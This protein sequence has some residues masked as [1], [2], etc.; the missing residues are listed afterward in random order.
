VKETLVVVNPASG[1]GRTKKRWPEF[2]R[3]LAGAGL[4]FQV[5]FTT[6]PG[7][8]TRIAR[9]GV[10]EGRALIVAAGGDGTISETA[11]GFFAEGAPI[12]GETRFGVLPTG[13]G[14]DFRRTFE[15]PI[16]PPAAAA[17]L[18][19]GHRR[20]IDAGLVRFVDRDGH[21]E[22][23]VF[24]NIADAG[25]GGD[26]VHR[27]NTGPKSLPGPVTFYLA[28][29][30]S[31]LAWRNRPVAVTIDGLRRELVSQQVV[32]ANCQ[33][34]GG[35]MRM[36]PMAVPDDGLLD[37]ILIG[38]VNMIEN[39]RGLGKIRKGTH[40]EEHH[41]K[42]LAFRGRRIEVESAYPIPLDVDGEGPGT[43]PAIF[44]VIPHALDLMVPIS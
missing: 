7:D 30:R 6:G 14:G 17:V 18:A 36:A 25:I 24:V 13:T 41:P 42:W 15:I 32:V 40:L 26:V 8:A 22:Q 1:G 19:G 31:L 43:L 10:R 4:D 2:E 3:A 44:E 35:G 5:T 11:G 9:R 37:V 39:A 21:P 28:T 20:R 29:V 27:V 23:R 38:D 33:Y 16:D 34:F 12:P